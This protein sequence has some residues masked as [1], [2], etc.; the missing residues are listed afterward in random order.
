MND[1]LR[2]V[3]DS[4]NTTKFKPTLAGL[5]PHLASADW[6]GKLGQLMSLKIHG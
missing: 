5:N 2:S 6:V 3:V 1:L 4:A